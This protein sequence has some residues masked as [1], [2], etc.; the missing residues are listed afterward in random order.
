[1]RNALTKLL[2]NQPDDALGFLA[3]YFENLDNKSSRIR[4]AYQELTL[5]HYSQVTFESNAL[6]AYDI[7]F[8]GSA[9]KKGRSLYGSAFHDL[10][11]L[12]CKDIPSPLVERLMKKI[13]C[14]DY[15]VVSF[16]TFY[17]GVL[18]C[19]VIIEYIYET[20]NLYK[21]MDASG[22]NSVNRYLCTSALKQLADSLAIPSAS[23]THM[24]EAG[25]MLS[26]DELGKAMNEAI[27]LGKDRGSI[28][29]LEEF[30][31]QSAIIY[32]DHIKP[33]R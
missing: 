26:S 25:S 19:F 5:S 9:Q 28:M 32:I 22:N 17:S 11:N 2:E 33:L 23:Q 29:K 8:S 30:V 4:Y 15:E 6:S 31:E 20:T 3:Q 13:C 14:R 27:Y 10:L 16:Q 24:L 1:M 7:L 21:V 12:I 18:A